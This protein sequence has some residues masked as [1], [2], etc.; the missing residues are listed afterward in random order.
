MPVRFHPAER[1]ARAALSLAVR[2]GVTAYDGLYLAQAAAEECRL[3]T[4]DR[5]LHET[6]RS[7]PLRAFVTWIGEIQ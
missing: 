1:L 5:R 7:G 4:A 2:Y 3:V 6:C